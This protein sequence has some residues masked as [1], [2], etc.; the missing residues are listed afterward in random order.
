MYTF[1][2]LQKES[3]ASKTA[4]HLNC[5]T[6]N[7]G[8]SEF[9]WRVFHFISRAGEKNLYCGS[10]I[11]HSNIFIEL[12]AKAHVLKPDQL[13]MTFYLISQFTTFVCGESLLLP[14]SA[15]KFH[16]ALP[17]YYCRDSQSERG[18]RQFFALLILFNCRTRHANNLFKSHV[19]LILN[20]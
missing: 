18:A 7:Q 15:S 20:I 2:V 16:N 13:E 8:L 14:R 6:D 10:T 9:V 17:F 19:I 3:A 4:V 5:I 11:S 12:V 1:F